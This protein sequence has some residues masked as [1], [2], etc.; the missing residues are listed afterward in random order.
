M[1]ISFN[2]LNDYLDLDGFSINQ[3]AGILTDLGL[4][5]ANVEEVES[6]KGGL[7][8]VIIGEVVHCERHPNADKLSLTRVDIGKG[9]PLQIV[10]GAPNVAAGQKVPVATIGTK[11][12]S[13]EGEE[14]EIRKGK[15]RGEVS[16]GMICAE[17]ELGLGES[18][19]GIMV[20]PGDVTIGMS[21]RDY[22]QVETDYVFEI[23]L[24]PNR[25][26]AT[27][28]IGV[29]L[30]LAAYL[31]LNEGHSGEVRFPVIEEQ[32]PTGPGLSVEVIVEDEEACP[33]YSGVTI[34]GIEIKSSPDWMQN[35]L[36]AIGVRPINNIVDITNYI[37]HEY[38][39]PLHAFDADKINGGKIRVKKLKEGTGFISL[40]EM[41]RKLS[42]EDLMIC[43]DRSEGL[44]IAGVFGGIG[45][46]VTGTTKNVFLESA[47]FH[48]KTVRK[49]SMRHNLRTDAALVF[50][51]GSDPAI[52]L[53][54]L[55]HAAL[56]VIELAG[57]KLS[58]PFLDKYP[59]PV[60]KARVRVRYANVERLIGIPLGKEKL[61]AIFDALRMDVLESDAEGV[62]LTVPTSKA[63]V[64]REV[65]VIEEILRVYG[66]NNIPEPEKISVSVAPGQ[67]KENFRI[68][69]YLAE[70][71][72]ARSFNEAMSLSL[73]MSKKYLENP[74]VPKEQLV[75]INNTSNV[76]LDV[77]RP[78]LLFSALD[79]LVY[80]QN[81]QQ[82][83]VLLFEF[84]KGYRMKGVQVEENEWLS[85]VAMGQ[86]HQKSW[87]TGRMAEVDYFYLKAQ[88]K[89]LFLRMNIQSWQELP[90][91][92][93][94]FEY[95]T[96]WMYENKLL[97]RLGKV[98]ASLARA[99]GLKQEVYFAE[100]DFEQLVSRAPE[101]L[102]VR[103]ISKFPGT[104]RDL[105]LVID[106]SR[107]FSEISDLAFQTIRQSLQSVEL[108]DVYDNEEQLGKGKISYAI[109]LRFEDEFKTL[110]DKEVD[111]LM[112]K[113]IESLEHNLHVSVRK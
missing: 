12:F 13:P 60:E 100:V 110:K 83:D 89:N 62:L 34:S 79:N 11:L 43:D 90:A 35:R 84:G 106:R 70:Y 55:K 85:L 9:Q 48:A 94:R 17:D 99:F 7:H 97:A 92:D 78:E 74:V 76:Q 2:W 64:T 23:E 14:W 75:Y 104:S 29:A 28:H 112:Q 66:L 50:E 49:T 52:T 31:K 56:L 81:R 27:S 107:T 47:H 21:A 58:S 25:S 87:K 61:A 63:D 42:G 105:A 82:R 8:G 72:T 33:R 95:A 98:K 24:T 19:E 26:D 51:K 96:D 15:I 113:F 45:S 16:E 22:F 59:T 40:D 18:H 103:E 73:T 5:V 54:A 6:V 44:C 67:R 46:G 20:L 69:K 38:G 111:K 32:W 80:N 10:C 30:D 65:D 68:R 109:S 53:S 91:E 57:G 39:Q 93:N 88:V 86:L 102:V 77:L 3:I 37:L 36:K 4:E 41:N 108:F 101:Q 71:L 1:K